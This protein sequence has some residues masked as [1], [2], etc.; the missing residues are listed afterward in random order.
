[1]PIFRGMSF[2]GSENE[3]HLPIPIWMKIRNNCEWKKQ[4]KDDSGHCNTIL[5]NPES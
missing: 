5:E 2:I 1:M 3:Q 4:V